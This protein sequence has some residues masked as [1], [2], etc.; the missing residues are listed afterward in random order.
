MPVSNIKKAVIPEWQKEKVF[1]R[2]RDLQKNPS[3]RI[4]W[5]EASKKIKQLAK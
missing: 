1:K 5:N 4:N 2:L 3:K